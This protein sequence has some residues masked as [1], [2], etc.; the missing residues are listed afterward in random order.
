MLEQVN[1]GVTDFA[2]IHG[3]FGMEQFPNVRQ[4]GAM[5]VAP[6][7][8]L[9]KKEYHAA[10]SQDLRNLRGRTINL[11][12]GK[13]TV[14]YWLGQELLSF[15]GLAAED[16][17]PLVVDDRT[18]RERDRG[19]ALARRHFYLGDAPLRAG[20][21]AGRALRFRLVPMPFGDASD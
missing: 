2:I 6:I 8:L 9:V 10:V 3:G 15:V 11:G 19:G 4:V 7:H 14:M 1:S 5:S 16:Y 20:S 12:N 18:T 21:P 13:H 17:R